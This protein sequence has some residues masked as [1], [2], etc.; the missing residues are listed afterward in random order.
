MN[1]QVCRTLRQ[2]ARLATVGKPLAL[3]S[4]DGKSKHSKGTI[5]LVPGC[6]R[7]LYKQAK[8]SIS[9]V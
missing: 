7:Y 3:Y 8:R 1:E 6:T 2:R 4:Y 5:R 9:N